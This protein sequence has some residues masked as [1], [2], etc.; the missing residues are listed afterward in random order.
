MGQVTSAFAIAH[1]FVCDAHNPS[2]VPVGGGIV[3]LGGGD[4]SSLSWVWNRVYFL[5]TN[6]VHSGWGD[7]GT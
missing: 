3:L 2:L 4:P 1:P 5:P 6:L 7:D